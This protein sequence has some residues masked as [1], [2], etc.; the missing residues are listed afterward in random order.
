MKKVIFI[1][2]IS[3]FF[4]SSCEDVID[5][6]LKNTNPI[7]VIDASIHWVKGTDGKTQQIKL[8]LTAPYFDNEIPSATGATVIITDS[9]NNTFNFIEE[10]NTGIYQTDNFIPSLNTTYNLNINYN[11]EVYTSTTIL[12]PVTPIEFVEQK[13]DGGFAG[14]ETE[15]K[16]FYT[17]PANTKN[18]YLFEFL[19]L[20]N[21]NISL[22]VYDDK[23]TDGNQIFGFF[24]DEDIETGDELIIRNSGIT[25]QSYNYLFV[26]L[27]QTV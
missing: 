9:N 6:D 22:E 25:E 23:F 4:I 20:N 18:F 8:S 21:N 1:F 14:N 26:L 27:Q 3:A 5:V 13:N 16:A 17:D 24:S 2:C 12:T 11:N 10:G 15:I 7:L 19:V